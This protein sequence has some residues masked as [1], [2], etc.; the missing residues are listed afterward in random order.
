[1]KERV[2]YDRRPR[3]SRF[4]FVCI[5]ASATIW[6]TPWY[7]LLLIVEKIGL[8]LTTSIGFVIVNLKLK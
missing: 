3:K 8:L 2:E 5:F 7:C 6:W 1:M 4:R